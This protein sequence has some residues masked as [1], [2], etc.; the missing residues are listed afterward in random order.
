M[1]QLF[2]KRQELKAR[3]LFI[4]Q[5]IDLKAFEPSKKLASGPLA[6]TAG[7]Q[8]IAVIF[9]Y[10]AAVLF[11]LTDVEEAAF[12]SD[13]Q[14]MI[15]DPFD[16]P[17][18]E[19]VHIIKDK[20]PNEGV[21]EQGISLH[22]FN[23]E[24]LQL[25]ADA[26]AKSAVLAHYET[27]L[28]SSFDRIAPLAEDLK[29]G[30]RRSPQAKEL[31]RHIGDALSIQGNMTGRIEVTEKPDLLWDNPDLE[32]LYMR[33][34]DEYE[35]SE[36]HSALGRKLD[37]ISRTAETLLGLLQAKRSLRV[38]WY[39]VILIV[40]EIILSLHDKFFP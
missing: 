12:L 27:K 10:G 31:L 1:K 23:I 19:T 15:S 11:G 30:K 34:E 40:F 3:A 8:G 16:S 36:R 21:T 24:R 39:I 35:I 14:A 32:R 28:A 20:T 5:R 37:L 2:A 9:R 25:L 4:G 38:E 18:S 7:Q 13:M 17:E 22:D 6:L 33:L 29:K 26:L